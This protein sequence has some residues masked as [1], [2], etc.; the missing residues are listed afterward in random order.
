[1]NLYTIMY[2]DRDNDHNLGKT[3]QCQ[4]PTE[5]FLGIKSTSLPITWMMGGSLVLLL[6]LLKQCSL[7]VLAYL[8][9]SL[10]LEAKARN[11]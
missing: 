4:I 3:L 9:M 11:L 10:I 1:M 2:V 5:G 8:G 6:G 7:M